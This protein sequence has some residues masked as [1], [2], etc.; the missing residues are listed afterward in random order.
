MTDSPKCSVVTV[1]AHFPYKTVHTVPRTTVE[2][3]KGGG[4]LFLFSLL[5]F[6]ST[7]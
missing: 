3:E 4:G 7:L 1:P 5:L 6:A 2:E